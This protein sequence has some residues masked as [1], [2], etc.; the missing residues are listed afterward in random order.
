MTTTIVAL[1]P[2]ALSFVTVKQSPWVTVHFALLLLCFVLFTPL[3]FLNHHTARTSSAL[4][5]LFFPLYLILMGVR[6][7]TVILTGQFAPKMKY[8]VEGRIALAR[9]S[10]WIATIGIGLIGFLLELFTPEKRWKKF[11]WRR[12]VG[13]P[14]RGEGKIALDSDD[15]E[16]REG[17]DQVGGLNGEGAISASVVAAAGKNEYGDMESP[18]V[19]ANVFE[20]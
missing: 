20:R 15:E 4:I 17:Y 1:A 10:L 11:S 18:V 6:L 3:S 7:R 9:E 16:D 13:L 8:T 2:L 14:R 19:T 5:L 12:L